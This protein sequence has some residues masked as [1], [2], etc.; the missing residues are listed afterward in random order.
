[1]VAVGGTGVL[2]EVGVACGAATVDV[3]VGDGWLPQAARRRNTTNIRMR[4]T[5]LL[6]SIEAVLAYGGRLLLF[7]RLGLLGFLL[8]TK[9]HLQELHSPYQSAP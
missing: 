8:F 3:S 2:V 9:I 5:G 4:V 6:G 7:S 1:M